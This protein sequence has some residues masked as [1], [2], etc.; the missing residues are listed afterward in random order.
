MPGVRKTNGL[1]LPHLAK[2]PT[3]IRGLDDIT[4]GGLPKQPELAAKHDIL[5]TPTLIKT[6]PAPVRRLIG[7]LSNTEKTLRRLGMAVKKNNT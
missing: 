4:G 5:A 3:G 2:T 1:P 7:D 6:L